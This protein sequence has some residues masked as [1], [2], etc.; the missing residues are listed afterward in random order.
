MKP[1]PAAAVFGESGTRSAGIAGSSLEAGNSPA[2]RAPHAAARPF[3]SASLWTTLTRSAA[4]NSGPGY[5]DLCSFPVCR[6][7]RVI[8]GAPVRSVP[9]R[10]EARANPRPP[11]KHPGHHRIDHLR[12]PHG[13]P[14]PDV[15]GGGGRDPARLADAATP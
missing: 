5:V 15:R 8:A 14:V 11:G 10:K 2:E 1:H 9:L 3:H 13:V 12:A 4:W 7:F 6:P